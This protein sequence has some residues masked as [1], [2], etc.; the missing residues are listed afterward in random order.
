MK[1]LMVCLGNICRSPL[2]EG[3]L[4]DKAGR[5]GLDI[6]VD[7]AGTAG[8]HTGEPP[9]RNSIR[10]AAENDLDIS[11]LRARQFRAKDFDEFDIIFVMDASNYTDV[12]RLAGSD[13]HRDKVRYLLNEVNPGSSSGVPDPWY[14][15]YDGFQE[16]YRLLDETCDVI[17]SNLQAAFQA[18]QQTG[19]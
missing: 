8:Y 9:H 13:G 15:G 17:I 3:I 7:S 2:A 1:I 12:I 11:M 6:T 10:V 4:R 19:R 16:V 14:G 5:S 18:E